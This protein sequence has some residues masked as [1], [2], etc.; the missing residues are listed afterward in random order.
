MTAAESH[1]PNRRRA[2]LLSVVLPVYNEAAILQE[3]TDSLCANLNDLGRSGGPGDYEIIYI[4][5]GSTDGSDKLLD[6]LAATNQK[7][8]VVHFS[9]NFGHQPA[10][11]AGLKHARGDAV[12]LMDS[13]MQDDPQAVG[14]MLTEWER[15]FDVVYAVRTKR[16]ESL[17]KRTLFHS[18][19]RLMNRVGSINVPMDA[20]NFGLLD[21]AV[22]NNI[23]AVGDHERYLPGIR[24]W[25]GFRQTGVEVERLARHDETPRVSV[26]Q[27]FRLAKSA[28]F[29]FS[30]APMAAFSWCAGIMAATFVALF[31]ATATCSLYSVTVPT[32]MTT[33]ATTS[34][35][36][37]LNA[38]GIAIV[39]EYVVRI[40]DQVR[41]RPR[42]I[43]A[44]TT[45]T[46]TVHDAPQR[47]QS[48]ADIDELE[49]LN[50]VDEISRDLKENSIDRAMIN[51]TFDL[52][53]SGN[54][55][56]Q[57]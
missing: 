51:P 44:R 11:H 25:V 55:F 5:D 12:V 32:W 57:L 8:R 42:Y 34:F 56:S 1:K 40:H 10:V 27:L 23:L 9:R 22:V 6:E 13:D 54:Y 19:Y 3:L 4:N 33:L 49:L 38:V 14:K 15:G 26:W 18:F 2:E 47:E 16:K 28:I 37:A 48:A 17:V 45:N 43:V 31:A 35:F 29:G 20:G 21:R 50:Q 52:P 24:S 36:A 7:I 30:R 46:K 41:N 39:G 53:T